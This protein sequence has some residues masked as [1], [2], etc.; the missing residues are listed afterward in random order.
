MMSNLPKDLVEEILSRVPAAALRRLRSTCKE[1]NALLDDKNSLKNILVSGELNLIDPFYKSEVDISNIY[2]CNGL[3]LCTTK[4]KTK[5]VI[6]NPC[7]GQTKWIEPRDEDYHKCENLCD[8]FGML[9]DKYVLGYETNTSSPSYKILRVLFCQHIFKMEIYEVNSNSWRVLDVTPDW[10]IRSCGVALKENTYWFGKKKEPQFNDQALISFNYT[11]ERFA[12]LC[13]PVR[14]DYG[15][16]QLSSIREEKLS[17]LY[18]M[19]HPFQ[20]EIWVTD[21]IKPDSV[22][23][24]KFFTVDM[25]K[26]QGTQTFPSHMNFIIEEE[27]KVAMFCVVKMKKGKLTNMVYIVGEDELREEED[28]GESSITSPCPIMFSYVPS[29]VQI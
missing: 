25:M 23:W 3:L 17:L 22:S 15:K 11:S 2:H 29:L 24:S 5:L 20:I 19:F 7:T 18:M 26:L 8:K 16:V 6:W 1:W 9:Y 10:Y 21:E 14:N 4:D 28:F 13:I 12:C 27:Q